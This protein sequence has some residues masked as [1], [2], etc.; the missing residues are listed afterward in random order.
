MNSKHNRKSGV[1]TVWLI[2]VGGI[3]LS[4][5][6]S[7]CGGAQ[8]PKVYHVG[9]LTY[10]T[11]FTAIGAGFKA[12]MA[13]LGYTEG[14]NI[15]YNTQT[16]A[17]NADSAEE[18][19]LAKILVDAKVDL[20]VAFPAPST[21]A[22]S[23][24]TQGT[25]I[26]VVFAYYQIEGS[27]LIKSVREPGGN[28]TGVRYPGS[29]LMSRRLDLLLEMAPQVKRAWIGYDKNG[30]N[31]A[32]ALEALRQSA[33]QAGI[34]LVEV[35]ATAMD[36]LAADLA[37]RAKSADIGLDAIICMPDN[38]S[39]APDN[40]AV[41]SKF[42]TE[43]NLPLAGGVASQVEQGAL[44]ING[45]DATK[46]GELVAPVVIKVLKGTP[47]GTLPVVTPDQT[48]VINYKVAQ[49]LGLTIPDGLLRQANKII[50]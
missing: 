30:P 8:Q 32:V 16:A 33:A 43:H 41:L 3:I 5:L 20:I 49:Q 28:M 21:V 50:R 36:E 38:F 25:N 42:A 26:P 22:A 31:T 39:T 9:I 19:R 4:L 13:A 10:G 23:A 34:T 47:A 2:L 40:F 48:L 15:V 37:A 17:A 45:T 6:L 1:R 18:L 44:F 27:N 46:V 29:E 7:G 35:P 24:A 14:Q 12:K 11:S